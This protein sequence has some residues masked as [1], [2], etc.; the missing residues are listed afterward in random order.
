MR[1]CTSA[2]YCAHVLHIFSGVLCSIYHN[3]YSLLRYFATAVSVPCI[4]KIGCTLHHVLRATWTRRVITSDI[5]INAF[6]GGLTWVTLSYQQDSSQNAENEKSLHLR[7][8]LGSVLMV[9]QENVGTIVFDKRLV[10]RQSSSA[11]TCS[12]LLNAAEQRKPLSILREARMG[13]NHWVQIVV[14]CWISMSEA[15]MTPAGVSDSPAIDA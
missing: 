11:T 14:A 10:D 8:S 1:D 6:G 4:C 7:W 12:L 13:W 3:L 2:N 5:V 15:W 9:L